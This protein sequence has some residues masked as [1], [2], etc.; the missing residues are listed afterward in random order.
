MRLQRILRQSKR[1]A[2]TTATPVRVNHQDSTVV[3][4]FDGPVVLPS[5]VGICG[6]A[7]SIENALNRNVRVTCAVG[8]MADEDVILEPGDVA[9]FVSDGIDWGVIP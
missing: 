9:N 5:P 1:G 6:Y 2:D 4:R 3:V 8:W 7:K